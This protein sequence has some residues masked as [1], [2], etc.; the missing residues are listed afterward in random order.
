MRIDLPA[1]KPRDAYH[2]LTATIFPRPIA[3]VTT[4]SAHGETNLAPFSFFQGVT[5]APPALL[6][7]VS[8]TRDGSRKDTLRNLE[9]VPEFVVNT[10]P[11]ALAGQMNAT[12]ATLPYG[13]SEIET[14]HV[15]TVPSEIVRPPRVAKSPVNFECKVH[16]IVRVGEGPIAGNIVIGFIQTLHV[17]PSVLAADGLPDPGKLDHIARLGRSSYSMTRERFDLERP[18]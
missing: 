14:F 9:E 16:Q 18:E 8:N 3:W 15:E 10:V 12:S 11:H 13:E 17:D 6:F 5:A 4:I 1:L 7:V 2:W